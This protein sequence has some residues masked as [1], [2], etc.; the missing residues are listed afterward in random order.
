MP[1]KYPN[2]YSHHRHSLS[3]K[4]LLSASSRNSISSDTVPPNSPAFY[5]NSNPIRNT[6]CPDL[7]FKKDLT[8]KQLSNMSTETIQKSFQ[9]GIQHTSEFESRRNSLSF[10]NNKILEHMRFS[11]DV[12][13]D[14]QDSNRSKR[15]GVVI[16]LG[17]D[18][19]RSTIITPAALTCDWDIRSYG[20]F[21]RRGMNNKERSNTFC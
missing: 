5:N 18:Q 12:R 1:L 17:I 10:D 4:P 16:S 13:M 8:E 20:L 3:T 21:Q 14:F 19:L 9:M 11:M 6:N 2:F 15:R 7:L